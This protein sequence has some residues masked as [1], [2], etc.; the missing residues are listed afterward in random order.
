MIKKF[1]KNHLGIFINSIIILV[2]LFLFFLCLILRNDPYVC[3]W[4][5]RNISRAYQTVIG[6]LTKYIPF[7]FMEML[8]VSL[9]VSTIIFIIL[10]IKDIRNRNI[11][12]IIRNSLTIVSSIFSIFVTFSICMSLN[13]NRLAIP[14]K[15]YEERVNQTQYKEIVKYFADDYSLCASNLEFKEDGELICP[16]TISELNY[17]ISLEYEKLNDDY[18]HKFTTNVKPM[19]SSFIYREFRI[20]GL[21]FASTGEANLNYYSVTSEIPFVMMHELAHSKGV[22]RENDANILAMYLG[23]NSSDYYIRYS[24]YTYTFSSLMMLLNY[25]GVKTDYAEVYYSMNK[26]IFLHQNYAYDYWVKRYGNYYKF[27]E[28]FNNLFLVNNGVEE[29][30][31]SYDDKP[32]I[33]EDDPSDISVYSNYQKLY[34]EYYFN[35]S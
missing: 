14:I 24:T 34:F 32:E 19:L 4:W 9:V 25:T 16:Y 28:W 1:I 13:Y 23:L 27:A 17:L 35:R 5:T 33:D 11:N 3:E 6:A 22:A 26:N 10:I 21:Y 2:E 15:L 31:G 12:G 20:T 18:Y 29:G 8:I 30:T 7:S